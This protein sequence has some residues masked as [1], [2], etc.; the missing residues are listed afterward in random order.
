MTAQIVIYAYDDLPRNITFL[1]GQSS[2]LDDKFNLNAKRVASDEDWIAAAE[3]IRR[4]NGDFALL[5]DLGFRDE[6]V[7]MWAS[8][9]TS[10]TIP[11][12]TE[13]G[14]SLNDAN[15]L[16][17]PCEG[18][19]QTLPDTMLD[20]IAL[21]VAT[22]QNP[23]EGK[24]LVE[25]VSGRGGIGGLQE[26]LNFLSKL[27][28][29]TKSR[30]QIVMIREPSGASV[31]NEASA[32]AILRRLQTE[33]GKKFPNLHT[34]PWIN[35]GITKWLEFYRQLNADGY[36]QRFCQH[37]EVNSETWTIQAS[38]KEYNKLL[39]AMFDPDNAYSFGEGDTNGIKALL[40]LYRE[41]SKDANNEHWFKLWQSNMSE[42]DGH[43]ISRQYL[44]PVL[45]AVFEGEVDVEH[46]EMRLPLFPAL[47]FLLSLRAL[48]QAMLDEPNGC[49][50]DRESK[51]V[52]KGRDGIYRL[53]IP[54]VQSEPLRFGLAKTWVRKCAPDGIDRTHTG[55]CAKLWSASLAKVNVS[56]N[57]VQD[58][59]EIALLRLFDG[60]GRPVVGVSFAPH[61]IHLHWN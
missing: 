33:W 59:F 57:A 41:P 21:L 27:Y 5:L 55:V 46:D 51:V 38:P 2:V 1:N 30:R 47:P 42:L 11:L 43:R 34:D 37:G 23:N 16:E 54:L 25:I 7:S 3:E 15:A 6:G 9:K 32:C 35:N 24:T 14:C 36:P 20:G 10:F 18:R 52:L 49:I 31:E 39:A 13:A 45:K 17:F 58:P 56:S 12:L 29:A 48:V 50:L 26:F 28:S 4:L 19:V 61:F 40:M 53:S 22:L 44:I 8:V 60:P